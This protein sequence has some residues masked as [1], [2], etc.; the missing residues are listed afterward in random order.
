MS[1]AK[2]DTAIGYWINRKE[3]PPLFPTNR[4]QPDFWEALGRTIATFG[5]L[6]LI[7]AQA[8]FALTGT[9]RSSNEKECADGF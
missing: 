3:L 2:G 4:H 5:F 8:I 1:H 6:E 7:L 9:R